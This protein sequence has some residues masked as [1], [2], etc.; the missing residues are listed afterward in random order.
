MSDWVATTGAYTLAVLMGAAMLGMVVIAVAARRTTNEISGPVERTAFGPVAHHAVPK[1]DN[2]AEC[3]RCETAVTAL[4]HY[5][6]PAI[7][8]ALGHDE[9]LT[10]ETMQRI[11]PTIHHCEN[12]E[13]SR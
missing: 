4:W 7:F 10:H 2:M 11:W 1:P 13:C 12:S 6:R 8:A 9:P 5:E 3:S